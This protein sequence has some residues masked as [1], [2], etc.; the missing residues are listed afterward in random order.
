MLPVINSTIPV[1]SHAQI[2]EELRLFESRER[3]RLGLDEQPA[4]PWSD[5]NPQSFRSHERTNTTILVGGLTLAHDTLIQSALQG[6]GYKVDILDCPDTRA[7]HLGKEFGNRG[8]CNPTYFTVGNL[9]K[10]LIEMRDVL[11]I[12]V[13]KI[14]RDY[15]FLTAGSCGPCRFGT[16]VTE[17]RKALR[18]AGFEDFRVLLFQQSAGIKQATGSDA[19]LALTPTFFLQLLKAV[20]AGDVLNI[21]GYR[22]RPYEVVPGATDAALQQSRRILSEALRC[23]GSVLLA[24]RRCRQQLAMVKVNRLQPK[25]KVMIIGEFW[26]MT[27]EGDGNYRLQRFLEEEG[28]EVDIQPITAWILYLIWEVQ[29]DTRR[30]LK[31]R[32]ADSA[33]N[34]DAPANGQFL[35]A[36]LWAAERA[37]RVMF[38]SFAAAIGLGHYQLPDMSRIAEIAR[39]FY[40]VELRGGEGHMEVGKLIEAVKKQKAHMVISVKPFGC[41][42]SASVSDGVQASVVTRH[43]DAIFCAVET[44]GD[45]AVNFQ[46]RVQMFLFKARQKARAEFEAALLQRGLSLEA[47]ENRSRRRKKT[48]C[49]YPS[50]SVAGTGA[51]QVLES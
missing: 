19:G 40:D 41:M 14:E 24:L 23:R 32:D 11:G 34:G 26:A 28:A 4:T 12:P 45:G 31:L 16:Y 5:P 29:H 15:L 18:D 39:D 6:M 2:E 44:T 30:R 27:T 1:Q 13:E 37:V 42:P 46:S 25:P 38:R 21:I 48:A 35:L 22:I 51:N 49:Y 50:H 33:R 36:K 9:V 8:Q 10:R 47:A 17:Y 3:V 20:L 43:P 7:L